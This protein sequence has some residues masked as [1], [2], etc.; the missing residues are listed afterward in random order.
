[1]SLRLWPQA[2]ICFLAL[3]QMLGSAGPSP[4]HL[5]NKGTHNTSSAT[6]GSSHRVGFSLLLLL[7]SQ[8]GGVLL[9]EQELRA[10]KTITAGDIIRFM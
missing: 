10:K 2:S 7:L 1:M 3:E 9:T 6:Q 4:Y 5:S 8:L